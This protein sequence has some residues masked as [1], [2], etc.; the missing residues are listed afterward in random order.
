MNICQ[1][2]GKQLASRQSLWNHNQKCRENGLSDGFNGVSVGEKRKDS[3]GKYSKF[4]VNPFL[5]MVKS[6]SCKR[7]RT[8]QDIIGYSDGDDD[9]DVGKDKM[10]FDKGIKGMVNRVVNLPAKPSPS[11]AQAISKIPV[12]PSG[13][14]E[15]ELESTTSKAKGLWLSRGH[16]IDE[17]DDE[18]VD[19]DDDDDDDD[20]SKSKRS[21]KRKKVSRKH[22]GKPNK[23]AI[24]LLKDLVQGLE[25]DDDRNDDDGNDETSDENDDEEDEKEKSKIEKERLSLIKSRIRKPKRKLMKL[26]RVLEKDDDGVDITNLKELVKTFLVSEEKQIDQQLQDALNS[27]KTSSTSVEIGMLLRVIEKIN[28]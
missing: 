14:V 28:G 26:L 8:R 6:P 21:R 19:D 10:K 7:Q 3:D 4:S 17:S 15:K 9:E 13:V 23:K 22:R 11:P 12:I 16:G 20:V 24:L 27:L 2:C 5:S 18:D 1:K 25:A